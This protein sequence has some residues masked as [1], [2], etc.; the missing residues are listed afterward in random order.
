MCC[1]SAHNAAVASHFTENKIKVLTI[2]YKVNK[3]CLSLHLWG[4]LL[5][6]FHSLTPFQPHSPLR[7]TSNT[8]YAHLPQ[9]PCTGHS[10][11]LK[12]FP[13]SIYMVSFLIS[14][15]SSL[16]TLRS[17]LKVQFTISNFI[18]GPSSPPIL[19]DSIFSQSTYH[20]WYNIYNVIYFL[21]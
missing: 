9:G 8:T 20:I 16:L 2:N 11:C 17:I 15:L 18:T 13:F 19:S 7:F 21:H 12:D 1:S 5:V 6:P 4:H 10:L 14:L 3:I